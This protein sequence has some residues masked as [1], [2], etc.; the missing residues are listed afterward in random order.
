MY[1]SAHNAPTNWTVR[2][3]AWRAIWKNFGKILI[4]VTLLMEQWP[5]V[6]NRMRTLAK[7]DPMV[8]SFIEQLNDIVSTLN[9]RRK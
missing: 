4:L 7:D 9:I 2:V 3:D 5:M 8:S 6:R 1:V